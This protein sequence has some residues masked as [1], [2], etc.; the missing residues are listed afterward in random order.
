M[1]SRG[2]SGCARS[3][4]LP[5]ASP[6]LDIQSAR[7]LWLLVGLHHGA[8]P[9]QCFARRRRALGMTPV[10]DR[11]FAEGDRCCIN[12]YIGGC[13]YACDGKMQTECACTPPFG[14]GVGRWSCK[15][16]PCAFDGGS[17]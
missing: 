9:R 17:G 14:F 4:G 11:D 2:R 7:S 3:P 16:T 13:H 5:L 6:W 15:S 10:L 1:P 8:F 12:Y